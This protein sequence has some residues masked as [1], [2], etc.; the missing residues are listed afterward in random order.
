MND[1]LI[2]PKFSKEAWS[3][4]HG[5]Q[6]KKVKCLNCG[7]E[8]DCDIPVLLEDYAAGFII[9]AHG[10]PEN[11]RVSTWRPFDEEFNKVCSDL[12]EALKDENA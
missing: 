7:K 8:F 6:T 9:K 5:I 4:L 10:C 1:E 12:F 3:E 2:Y 11:Y